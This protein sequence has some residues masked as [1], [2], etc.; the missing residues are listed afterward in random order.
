MTLAMGYNMLTEA[1]RED[2]EAPVKPRSPV[3]RR[4]IPQT[5]EEL[6]FATPTPPFVCRDRVGRW[7]HEHC[8]DERDVKER[9]LFCSKPKAVAQRSSAA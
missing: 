6:G 8:F 9:C 4:Q 7:R 3:V 5:G 2:L 1:Y